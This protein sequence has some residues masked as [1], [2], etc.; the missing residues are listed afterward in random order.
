MANTQVAL[1]YL[2]EKCRISRATDGSIGYDMRANIAEPV[3]IQPNEKVL[4]P[5]GVK[6]DL[7]DP[8]LGLFLFGRSGLA[9][10][11][12]IQLLNSVGVID[13]DFR[14][15]IGAILYNTGVTGEAFTIEPYDRVAQCIFI[16]A[17]EVDLVD[18]DALTVTERGEGGYN[19]TGVK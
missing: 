1:Q 18:K 6:A 14:G 7:G 11:H 4:I 3:T 9:L 13:S 16:R 8:N 12:G 19:S 15:E 5:L 10:K 17:E 2:N